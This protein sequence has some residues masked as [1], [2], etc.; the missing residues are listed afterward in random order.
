MAEKTHLVFGNALNEPVT[1]ER[2]QG[3]LYFDTGVE[4]DRL[5]HGVTGQVLQTGGHG[6][7]PSWLTLFSEQGDIL[8]YSGGSTIDGP[9]S[10][11]AM[12]AA[13][14]TGGTITWTN[15][16][17]AK[18]SNDTYATAVL[19]AN[20]KTYW[21]KSQDFGFNIPTGNIINGIK[22]EIE[23]K[24][25]VANDII[26]DT[27]FIIKTSINGDNLSAS[28]PISDTESYVS[29]GGI[30]SLWGVTWTAE[31]INASTFGISFYVKDNAG[32][33]GATV[34]VDHIRITV[35]HTASIAIDALHHGTDGQ[36]LQS[37]G[38]AAN[39][40][41]VTA[42]V[43]NATHTGDVTGGT[44]LTI[45]SE[46]VTYAKMQHVLA[47]K[48]LGSTGGG[49]VSEIACTA[50]GRAILDDANAAAQLVTLGAASLDQAILSAQVFS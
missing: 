36:I 42:P 40:S 38:H 15:P 26:F 22:A 16:N 18:I 34:S 33:S 3:D 37:G 1:T 21:L 31:E 43:A 47:N 7:N 19:A 30:S 12:A 48:V 8:T 17:N 6:A 20:E 24:S 14:G 29:F 44:T 49:D 32:N 27:V 41:W 11:N 9:N 39:L 35:Y 5:P 2:E 10:P 25:S 28:T 45:A 23:I 4:T 13:S 50:A 46:A